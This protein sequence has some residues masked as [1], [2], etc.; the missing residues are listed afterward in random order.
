M[1]NPAKV[2]QIIKNIKEQTKNQEYIYRWSNGGTIDKVTFNF[3]A[4]ITDY[5]LEKFYNIYPDIKL[6]ESYLTF[7]KCSNGAELYQSLTC[8]ASVICTLRPLQEAATH[9]KKLQ[10]SALFQEEDMKKLLPIILLEDI[11][12]IF[13]DTS[14]PSEDIG[15]LLYPFP[16]NKRFT[17]TF[18]TWLERFIIAQGNEY[19][20]FN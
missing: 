13:L 7:L 10:I 17:Y 8:D 4:P 3:N 6:P 14:L 20:Y 1:E 15:Y 19:W 5:E 11:G 12:E 9:M 2:Q 18:D 16:D